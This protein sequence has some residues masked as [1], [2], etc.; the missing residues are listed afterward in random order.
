MFL[1]S[2]NLRFKLD[3][4]TGGNGQNGGSGLFSSNGS[5]FEIPWTE[6]EIDKHFLVN[7]GIDNI[8]AEVAKTFGSILPTFGL[9]TI[10]W[11]PGKEYINN[12]YGAY[13]SK[14][15]SGNEGGKGG[16]GGLG[17][18]NGHAKIYKLDESL[19]YADKFELLLEKTGRRGFDGFNGNRGSAGLTGCRHVCRR[20]ANVTE[21]RWLFGSILKTSYEWNNDLVM[22]C[23]YEV[24]SGKPSLFYINIL[25]SMSPI[26][27]PRRASK[28]D[29]K[30]LLL[31]FFQQQKNTKIL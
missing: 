13:G 26:S 3:G 25:G 31:S 19:A 9:S 29:D 15:L 17:G 21:N 22:K 18:L 14:P 16:I 8:G 1:F 11:I 30:K 6:D 28:Y 2:D 23:V 10:V 20:T 5:T 12:V 4:G 7:H 27:N 24:S